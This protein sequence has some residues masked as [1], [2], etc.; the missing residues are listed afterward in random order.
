MINLLLLKQQNAERKSR[1]EMLNVFLL[2]VG[3][4]FASLPLLAVLYVAYNY[5]VRDGF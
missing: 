3:S 1:V 5:F 4:I 2:V